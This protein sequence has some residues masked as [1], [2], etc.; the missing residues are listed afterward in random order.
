MGGREGGKRDR[1][2]LPTHNTCIYIIY[3]FSPQASCIFPCRRKHR[4]QLVKHSRLAKRHALY[5]TCIFVFT[6]TVF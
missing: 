6:D 5:S 3:T 1:Y 4:M 2:V